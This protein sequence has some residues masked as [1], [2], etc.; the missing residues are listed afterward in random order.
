MLP[1]LKDIFDVLE[2]LAPSLAAEDWDNPGLQVGCFSQVIKKIL[3]SLD[4]TISALRE[5]ARRNA[6]LLL[7]HHPLVFGSLSHI[8]LEVYP[9][10]VICEALRKQVSIIAV[11]TNL[12]VV[13]GG[14]NDTLAG[15]F[16][17]E[18]LEVLQ[19]R[20]DSIIGDVGL[21][22]IGNLL[23]PVTL[24]AMTDNVKAVLG[25]ERVK[26]MGQRGRKIKRIAVVGGAGGGLVSISSRK[27]ADLLITGD[28]RHHEALE[29]ET[30]GLALID[31]GHFHTEKAALWPF[32][33]CLKNTLANRGWSISV[34]VYENEKEP[35]RYE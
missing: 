13:Q 4:P 25:L 8:N 33:N 1:R 14:I 22:R 31:G 27:G 19:K 17:L 26:V 35:M 16:S 9:G 18:G 3:I 12:D 20:E 24:S 28:V 29:A 21:G 32:G 10:N 34:E 2:Q 7:T 30:L 5:A 23:E 11:H 15:L 6:Q